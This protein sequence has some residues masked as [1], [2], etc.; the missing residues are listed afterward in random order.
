MSH[1][2]STQI[3]FFICQPDLVEVTSAIYARRYLDS[4]PTQTH[5][6]FQHPTKT[7]DATADGS[8]TSDLCGGW[9]N[10]AF[11]ANGQ[12]PECIGSKLT[13]SCV[14]PTCVTLSVSSMPANTS[15]VVQRRLS[16]CSSSVYAYLLAAYSYIQPRDL[17]VGL[18]TSPSPASKFRPPPFPI[19][20]CRASTQ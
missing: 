7:I 9:I 13:F 4:N 5:H 19:V 14:S 3:Q 18:M 2:L 12:Y 17:N 20:H 10:I 6:T 11:S 15:I 8:C 16:T 1:V